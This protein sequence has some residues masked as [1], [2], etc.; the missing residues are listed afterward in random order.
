MIGG[1]LRRRWLPL[2]SR[3]YSF[4]GVN[5]KLVFRRRVGTESAEGY[6]GANYSNNFT[7]RKRTGGWFGVAKWNPSRTE[8]S[9]SKA[10]AKRMNRPSVNS[11]R[12]RKRMAMSH[13]R[14]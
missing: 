10:N 8:W 6:A 4:S 14:S 11:C 3:R 1:T 5:Q 2:W 9:R 13:Q 12:P 7:S